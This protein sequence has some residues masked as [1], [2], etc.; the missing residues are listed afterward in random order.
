MSELKTESV[1]RSI[2]PL[3]LCYVWGLASRSQV[4]EWLELT[5]NEVDPVLEY[6][7]SKLGLFRI[8][9][10]GPATPLYSKLVDDWQFSAGSR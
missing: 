6:L 3:I 9:A 8:L 10:E 5:G 1:C 2:K 7:R 4:A